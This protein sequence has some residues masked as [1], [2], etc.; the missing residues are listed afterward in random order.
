MAL[1]I[2]WL[3]IS[4]TTDRKEWL[5]RPAILVSR[6]LSPLNL[7]SLPR[8]PRKILVTVSPHHRFGWHQGKKPIGRVVGCQPQLLLGGETAGCMLGEKRLDTFM[9]LFQQNECVLYLT[10]YAVRLQFPGLA[11]WHEMKTVV[12]CL[13]GLIFHWLEGLCPIL[14]FPYSQFL[15]RENSDHSV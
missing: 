8:Q 2:Q 7:P 6:L 14:P 11:T 1:F 10:A 3:N 9:K 13:I 5:S 12:C 4:L 15:N